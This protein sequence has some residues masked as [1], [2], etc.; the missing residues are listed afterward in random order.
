MVPEAAPEPI[1]TV[2]SMKFGRKFRYGFD[3]FGHVFAMLGLIFVD[4]GGPLW[5]S[6][7]NINQHKRFASI[8]ISRSVKS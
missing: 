8:R 5:G 7:F 1:L 6:I 2:F 4:L 3:A